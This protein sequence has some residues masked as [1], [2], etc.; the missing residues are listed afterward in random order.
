MTG[1]RMNDPNPRFSCVC[2]RVVFFFFFFL[3][4]LPTPLNHITYR[5]ASRQ[6]CFCR[7]HNIYV[8]ATGDH[9]MVA[10]EY[11]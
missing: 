11:K 5:N 7:E 2:V 6:I 3:K 8:K 4:L 9:L 10:E 1:G